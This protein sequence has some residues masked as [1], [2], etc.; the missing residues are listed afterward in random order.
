MEGFVNPILA[1]E[2]GRTALLFPSLT[3]LPEELRGGLPSFAQLRISFPNQGSPARRASE[4]SR[5]SFRKDLMAL[6]DGFNQD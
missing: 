1:E 5:I 6:A 2:S 4:F 3:L